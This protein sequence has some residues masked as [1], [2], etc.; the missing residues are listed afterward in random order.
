KAV[1]AGITGVQVDGMDVLAVYKAVFDAVERG[2]AGEGPTLV[3]T[4]TYRFGPHSLSGD[5]PTR[6]RSKDESGEWEQKDPLVRYRKFLAKKGLWTEEE[7]TAVIEEAKAAV[8]EAIKKADEIEK[9]TIPGLLDSVF[10]HTTPQAQEQK[11]DFTSVR[12]GK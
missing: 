6:Y 1:A 3:E 11:R 12:E 8:A 5:D 2:R 9:L 10:E 4:I 7:E